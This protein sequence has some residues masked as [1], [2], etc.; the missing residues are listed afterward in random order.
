METKKTSSREFPSLFPLFKTTENNIP[1]FFAYAGEDSFE[2]ELII[3]HYKETLSK[4]GSNFEIIV[5][6]SESG[7]QSKLFAELFTPDMFYPR[8]LIILKQAS[9][10][11]KPILDP[12]ASSEWKDFAV[13]FK[14]NI[15]SVSDQIHLI[16]HY[17]GKDIPQTLVNLFNGTLNH[18]KTK[19]LYQSD[20]A[21]TL[22]E[23][24][25][26]EKVNLDQDAFDEFIHRI[27]ANLGAYLKNIKKLKQ[28]L[29]KSKFSLADINSILFNQNELNV[30]FLVDSLVQKRKIEFFKEFTKFSDQNS[31]I[32]TFLTRLSYKLDEIRKIKVIRQ[33]HNGEIPIPVM[34]EILKTASFSDGRKNFMRRQLISESANFSDKTLN[35]FYEILIDMNIKFKSG[36]RDEEGR[37][38]FLQKILHC[39]SLL[40]DKSSK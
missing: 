7:E 15:T 28:Y 2:F 13:G 18:Y 36:L 38:Y 40:Q 9:S 27:P 37:N 32:L 21:K 35:E 25:E 26:Q 12:K 3:E 8:K 14:K 4:I 31:E 39:Y 34:D 22:K 30:G 24:C 17:D 20:Y 6:V 11:F 29:H 5:I 19:P 23:V 33:K 10:F 16:L 1:Q